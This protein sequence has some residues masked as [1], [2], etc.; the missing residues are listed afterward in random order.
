M[1][2][3]TT[4]Y[5]CPMPDC[6]W[7]YD[8]PLGGDPMDAERAIGDHMTSSHD[9]HSVLEYLR[10]RI[11]DQREQQPAAGPDETRAR[12]PLTTKPSL[13]ARMFDPFPRIAV[14]TT[15]GSPFDTIREMAIGGAHGWTFGPDGPYKSPGQT[16]AQVT[17]AEIN[18]ALLH[19]LELGVIDIDV[20]RLNAAPGWPIRREPRT[21]GEA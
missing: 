10:T 13:P 3:G 9:D 18:E 2:A 8:L 14:D 19:L 4:R 12:P 15:P 21:T 20:E 7:S 11:I 17:R 5:K 1:T 16:P 6:D